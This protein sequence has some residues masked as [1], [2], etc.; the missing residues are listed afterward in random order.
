MRGP[1][2]QARLRSGGGSDHP[3]HRSTDHE[4]LRILCWNIQ[5]GGGLRHEGIVTRI[6]AHDP[7]VVILQ[8]FERNSVSRIA[9]PLGELGWH[10]SI[11]PAR[12]VIRGN[13]VLSRRLIEPLPVR[14]LA[15]SPER[16]TPF[17]IADEDLVVGVVYG[18]LKVTEG[19]KFWEDLER[20]I[21]KLQREPFILL[22]DF[23][24]GRS[25]SDSDSY[26]FPFGREFETLLS[27][28]LVDLW[29]EKNVAARE[30]TWFY[31]GGTGFRIDHVLGNELASDRLRVC[32]YSH[33]ERESGIS[34]HSLIVLDVKAAAK[35]HAM[36]ESAPAANPWA[37][38][39]D[40]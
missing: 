16:W 35:E 34:D 38:N 37:A 15:A 9:Q 1:S 31:R 40:Q 8:E 29:R 26:R 10:H 14:E 22:G 2:V 20:E 5:Q 4:G 32:R 27:H 39:P 30:H 24:T 23:N 6:R 19:R 7:D 25:G 13:A 3:P 11:L 18:P 17:R 36:A 12:G 33:A 28:G 21:A